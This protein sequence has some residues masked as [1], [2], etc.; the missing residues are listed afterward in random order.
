MSRPKTLVLFPRSAGW[1]LPAICLLA[2]CDVG[3][4][5]HSLVGSWK[6][7]PDTTLAKETITLW[8]RK[9]SASGT[10]PTLAY[11][12]RP[13]DIVEIKWGRDRAADWFGG[14]E[15]LPGTK[16]RSVHLTDEDATEIRRLLGQLHPQHLS[17]DAP[18]ALPEGCNFID[19]DGAWN[20]VSFEQNQHAGL[21]IF[22]TG[23]KGSGARKVERHLRIILGKLPPEARREAFF[24]RE[25]H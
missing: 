23:C 14:I 10:F 1:P 8:F 11:V 13:D 16:S 21:F 17:E 2:S 15:R 6:V 9:Y 20:G 22:Q 12:V 3:G 5:D 24:D 7:P 19:D 25:R 18:F 4:S